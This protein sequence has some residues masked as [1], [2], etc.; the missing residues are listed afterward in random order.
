[1]PFVT[2]SDGLRL[3][4]ED[5]GDGPVLLLIHGWLE[6]PRDDL[7]P[8]VTWLA[9][10]YRVLAP[11]R[12]GYGQSRPPQ[13]D[14]PDDF[15]H[16]DAADALAFLDALAIDR[17]HVV[18]FSDGGETAL[19]AGGL[20]PDRFASVTAWGAVGYF[21]P[22]MRPHAQRSAPATFLINDP[23]LMARHGIT[24][25]KAYV[26]GW[27]RAVVRMID[28]G[29]DVSLSLAPHISAPLL[30]MLGENDRLN[31]VAYGQRF[32]DTAP[33]GQL[34]TFADTGHDIH[35]QQPEAF[36]QVLGEFLAA[37]TND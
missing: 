4:Y 29:G 11:T 18:G 5:E 28:R 27:I 14:Y 9:E 23:A 10:S 7:W 21:G 37:H 3:H 31:P 25:A 17:A 1:M 6:T 19:I 35:V 22:E 20:Q 32:V 8:L 30:I 33:N 16:R 36:R 13:R 12:R 15:Y 24:D 2:L 26:A 34:V